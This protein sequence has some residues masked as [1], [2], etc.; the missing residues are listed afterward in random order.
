M[1]AYELAV[2]A[3]DHAMEITE[4]VRGAD[5]LRSTARQILIYRALGWTP[6]AWYHAPLLL[7]ENGKRLA[8]RNDALSLGTLRELGVEVGK[9]V[10]GFAN[11]I[12]S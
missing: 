10:E 12:N 4:V 5:L 2:T 3:D 11:A 7:D 1:P 6:P 8:K 9:I